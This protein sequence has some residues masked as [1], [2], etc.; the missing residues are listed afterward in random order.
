MLTWEETA[1]SGQPHAGAFAH[2]QIIRRHGAVV[3]FEP[4]KIAHAMMRAFMAVHGALAFAQD[5]CSGWLHGLWRAIKPSKACAN[6]VDRAAGL[7][8]FTRLAPQPG[9]S[10]QQRFFGS[11][12]PDMRNAP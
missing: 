9:R 11:S 8:H 1:V 4:N 10:K 5:I 2:Y 6:G 3:P 7:D 12:K